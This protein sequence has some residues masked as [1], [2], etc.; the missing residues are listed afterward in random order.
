[1]NKKTI[2]II[3]ASAIL[4]LAIIGAGF[5]MMWNKMS[6]VV[7]KTQKITA[8]DTESKTDAIEM[9]AVYSL[10]TFI[11]NLSGDGGKRYLRVTM[12]LEMDNEKLS[13]EMAKRLPQIR[14]A[15]LMILPE[16]RYEDISDKKGKTALAKEVINTVNGLLKT[17]TIKN[18]YFTEFVIQ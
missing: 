17:G 10:D 9:G 14:N 8:Q 7:A 5:Y 12:D 18:I 3:A 6:S 1:M 15:I 2:I 4:F 11:V 16:K 13:E